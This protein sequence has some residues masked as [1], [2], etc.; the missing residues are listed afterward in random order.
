MPARHENLGG[1]ASV[2]RLSGIWLSFMAAQ[3]RP[4]ARVKE[5]ERPLPS[6]CQTQS[7][8]CRQ[9]GR[10]RRRTLKPVTFRADRLPVKKYSWWIRTKVLCERWPAHWPLTE[11]E[12]RL[13]GQPGMLSKCSNISIRT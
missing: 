3:L 9:N 6:S 12:S 4:T 2:S 13:R 10:V 5:K 7:K 1:W 8:W 11:Q